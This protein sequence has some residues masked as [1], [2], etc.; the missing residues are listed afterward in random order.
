MGHNQEVLQDHLDRKMRAATGRVPKESLLGG[1]CQNVVLER[2]VGPITN[3][4]G[5]LQLW[6]CL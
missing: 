5:S 4:F 6:D 2:N 1:P 3:L